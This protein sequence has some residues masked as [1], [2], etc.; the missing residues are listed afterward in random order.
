MHVYRQTFLQAEHA[1][2]PDQTTAAF[3][4]INNRSNRQHRLAISPSAAGE[5]AGMFTT[6][7]P[8]P[9][10]LPVLFGSQRTTG[11]RQS[12]TRH[13]Q[14]GRLSYGSQRTSQ[15]P[16]RNLQHLANSLEFFG[17]E[18]LRETGRFA[19]GTA[20]L[21]SPPSAPLTCL[22]GGSRGRRILASASA[23]PSAAPLNSGR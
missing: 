19:S 14:A 23:R 21:C 18:H 6:H 17:R 4:Q 22:T 1:G 5:P 3:W 9:F 12:A 2:T 10:K 7:T 11:L 15:S 13:S 16:R 20:F 8:S